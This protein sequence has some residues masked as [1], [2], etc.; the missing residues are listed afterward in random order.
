MIHVFIVTI[1]YKVLRKN[2]FSHIAILLPYK[3][4]Y[5]IISY[6]F[7]LWKKEKLIDKYR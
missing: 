6:T 5:L 7:F 4:M 1:S 3:I 2:I